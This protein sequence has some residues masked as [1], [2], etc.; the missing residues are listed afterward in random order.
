MEESEL[1]GDWLTQFRRWL[2]E[3]EAAGVTEPGAMVVATA[4]ASGA[5]GARHVLL[6]G[7]D[8]RGFTFFTNYG[9]RKAGE[10]D[11][12]PQAALLF[13]WRAP[14]HRQVVVDGT[15]ERVSAEESDAYFQ[16]RPHGSR[17][18][19]VASLQSRVIG[20]RE[21]LERSFEALAARHPE[22]DPP[23]RPDWWGGYRLA[24]HAVEFWSGRPNRLHDRLCFR[25]EGSEWIVERLAP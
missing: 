13:H 23:S 15:V 3:A 19:A 20:G 2:A 11:A 1:A 4:S 10:L 24:P 9:S 12:N 14:A 25:R 21:E 18:G 7:L 5:P 17:L 6:R 22:G 8:E 16:S